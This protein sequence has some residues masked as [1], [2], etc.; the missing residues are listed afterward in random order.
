MR[1]VICFAVLAA[2]AGVTGLLPFSPTEA[3]DL[4]VVQTLVVC[5]DADGRV[6]V[7]G[8]DGLS[9]AGAQISDAIDEL[10]GRVP[11]QLFLGACEQLVFAGGSTDALADAAHGDTLRPAVRVYLS[12]EPACGLAEQEEA[13]TK[14]LNAHPGPVRLSDVRAALYERRQLALPRLVLEEGAYEVL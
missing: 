2:L 14:Y 9:G 12:A 11:G 10:A 3:A 6:R 4:I 5:E 13:L 1:R 8:P 7:Y